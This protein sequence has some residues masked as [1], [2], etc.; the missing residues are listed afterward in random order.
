[1]LNVIF[2]ESGLNI[3]NRITYVSDYFDAM[4]DA[5]WL[6]S[7]L[8]RQIIKGVD[9]SEYIAGEYIESPVLG[10]ISPRDL[11]SGCKALLILLNENNIIVSGEKMGDNCFPW[12]LKIAEKKDV[13]IT[14]CHNVTL[15]EPFAVNNLNSGRIITSNVELM[16]A[17]ME[18]E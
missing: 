15:K 4:Y 18:E 14:L 7:E 5:T 17:L 9:D 16:E 11:S 13:T 1:M 10:G 12:L 6:Q 8:A 3:S 2:G